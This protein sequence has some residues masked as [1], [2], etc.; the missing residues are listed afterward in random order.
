M[1][2]STRSLLAAAALTAAAPAFAAGGHHA[3]DDAA[4][5]ETGQCQLETWWDREDGG[6]RS[7]LHAG[8]ACRL[9][10]VELGLNVDRLRVEG[11]GATTIGGAQI[12]W[13]SAF[14]SDWSAGVVIAAAA[15]DRSP[16]FLGGS[17]VVPITWQTTETLLTH[18]NLGREFWHHRPDTHRA[19]LALEW[20]PMDAWSFVAERFREGGV[21]VWRIGTRW[22]ITPQANVDLS[23]A[24]GLADGSP[25]WWTLGFTWVFER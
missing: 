20:A 12:K 22:T 17:V 18:V 14:S 5:L 11:N 4:L 25:S 2:A 24:R 1:R 19:G 13:A 15:W 9:G 7:L 8:P 6:D 16:K 10:A 3:V 21:N 23:R